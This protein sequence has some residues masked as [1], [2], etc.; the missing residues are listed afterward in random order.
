MVDGEMAFEPKLRGCGGDLP[1]TVR[2]HDATRNEHVRFLGYCLV[3]DIIQ[4]A[5]LVATEAE[6]GCVLTLHP[7]TRTADV[8]T[9]AP[10]WFEWCRQ[11]GEPKAREPLQPEGEG[12]V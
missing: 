2:L 6:A 4:L 7:K 5:Q 11:S 9:Q 12:V 10:H 3:Q 1:L 8:C